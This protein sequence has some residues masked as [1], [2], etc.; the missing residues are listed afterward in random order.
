M[1]RSGFLR[2]AKGAK[3]VVISFI[4]LL[5]WTTLEGSQTSLKLILSPWSKLI[6]GEYYAR[7][8]I[9]PMNSRAHREAYWK[10]FWNLSKQE[11]KYRGGFDC[12][13]F[14]AFDLGA[15]NNNSSV[16]A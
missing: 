15:T 9:T 10:K 6:N 1:V 7:C 2:E 13:K 5:F 16:Y 8:Q 4:S 11:M 14:E 3:K 12:E